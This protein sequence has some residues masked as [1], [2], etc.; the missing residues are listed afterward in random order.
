MIKKVTKYIFIAILVLVVMLTN[1]NT[2]N[3]EETKITLGEPTKDYVAHSFKYEEFDIADDVN[4]QSLT[5]SIKNGTFKVDADTITA[6][7][8]YFDFK[9]GTLQDN[10]FTSS[11]NGTNSYKTISLN[12]KASVDLTDETIKANVLT[13]IETFIKKIV[14]VNDTLKNAEFSVTLSDVMMKFD[15]SYGV[16]DDLPVVAFKG[17]D[18]TSDHYYIGVDDSGIAWTDAYNIAAGLKF[19]GLQGYLVTITSLEEHNFIYNSLESIEGWMGAAG[20]ANADKVKFNTQNISWDY[21]GFTSLAAGSY[22]GGDSQYEKN[23]RLYWH[24]VAGPEAGKKVF[25]GFT[26]FNSQEPNNSGKNEWCAEYGFGEGGN[27]NDYPNSVDAIDGYYVEFGGFPDDNPTN[28]PVTLT[29]EFKWSEYDKENMENN[30]NPE[31]I[32]GF[33]AFDAEDTLKN[34]VNTEI[35][36]INVYSPNYSFS[37]IDYPADNKLRVKAVMVFDDNTT[38]EFVVE[39]ELVNS[40]R[41]LNNNQS[42]PSGMNG[43]FTD[44]KYQVGQK[45]LNAAD[46]TTTEDV[47]V[48]LKTLPSTADE[49]TKGLFQEFVDQKIEEDN[50]SG[51]SLTFVDLELFKKIG[52]NETQ[53]H[54]AEAPIEIGLSMSGAL[55]NT[56]RKKLRVYHVLRYHD[57]VVEELETVTDYN[58]HTAKFKSDKFSN[59]AVYYYDIDNPQSFD[60]TSLYIMISILSLSMIVAIPFIVRKYED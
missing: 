37:E 34:K 43:N 17:P 19:N 50:L 56:N 48:T 4:P 58:T 2:I 38:Y 24:W 51:V 8:T 60:E 25:D 27:W 28:P 49:Y 5:I 14:F 46:K 55:K 52:E 35:N 21:Q 18:H 59:Y 32:T 20:I 1:I 13:S 45:A 42:A 10:S 57:D 16:G 40:F 7:V 54:V 44:T 53:V 31:N 6:L 9:G 3:A 30:F 26:K 39:K 12:T 15:N 29:Q 11:L 41:V 47:D 36:R 23:V 33:T 22:S